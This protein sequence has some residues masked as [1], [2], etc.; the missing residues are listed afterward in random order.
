VIKLEPGIHV[1]KAVRLVRPLGQGGMGKVWV[2]EHTGL[3]T[4]VVV[5]FMATEGADAAEAAARFTREAAA[6]AAVKSPHVVQMFDHGLT[7]DGVPYI[8]ME[9]L[10]G[11]DLGAFLDKH[12]KMAP[13]D[14]AAVVGQIAKALGKAHQVGVVHRDI[15][16]ENI[17]LCDGEGGELFVKVLDFGI[18]KSNHR[19]TAA[20]T[21]GQVIG[22]PFYMSPEQILGQ[23]V[24]ARSDIWSL[25]VVAFEALTG[26]RPFPGETI[27]AV[28]LAIHTSSPKPCALE[29]DLPPAVDEWFAK[30]C[31]RA[32]DDRFATVR[33][34]AA[35]LLDV[36]SAGGAG[37]VRA[38]MLSMLGDGTGLG[39]D[40]RLP[41]APAA[42]LPG[43]PAVATHAAR[44]SAPELPRER[45]ATNL[46]SS[47]PAPRDR[48]PSPAM[49]AVSVVAVLA[50]AVAGVLALR[51]GE[52]T[53]PR[54]SAGE[55][56]A[57]A[58]FVTTGVT[59]GAVGA[60]VPAAS[61][62]ASAVAAVTAKP[63]AGVTSP[64]AVAATKPSPRTTSTTSNPVNKPSKPVRKPTDDDI[65]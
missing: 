49:L 58:A 53:T 29:P 18:A 13:V 10:E 40:P 1:T 33:D 56:S 25:G 35:A 51:G 61:A 8:V 32:P 2:A 45:A 30:A 63:D 64:G 6:A 22:T 19:A 7:D 50:L 24:D 5:K 47:F 36:A 4:Q 48:K 57:S 46:S 9:L 39:S 14:V 17:F 59:T 38:P 26:K 44:G 21:T 16:P 28:T 55:P 27:G 52:A 42:P 3:A 54:P 43:D 12:G 23:A 60:P 15:K 34:A 11:R 31:A 62:S 20:T 65:K 41:V 37:R